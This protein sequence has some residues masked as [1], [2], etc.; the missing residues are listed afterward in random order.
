MSITG[1]IAELNKEIER[2]TKI[3]D[4]LAQVAPTGTSA[5]T[6]SSASTKGSASAKTAAPVRKK[7][8]LSAAARKKISEAN[9]ARWAR[10]RG[11]KAAK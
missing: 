9:K 2:L 4:S 5:K 8:V 3:R 1:A 7:R 6:A 10:I 11:A